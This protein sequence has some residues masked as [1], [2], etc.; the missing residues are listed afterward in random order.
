M[1]YYRRRQLSTKF[2]I[3]ITAAAI[4]LGLGAFY[5]LSDEQGARD[6]LTKAG[7]T[8]AQYK[9]HSVFGCGKGDLFK[10]SFSVKNPQGQRIDTVVCRGIFKGSTIRF[11]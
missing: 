6:T 7:Y 2:Q 4:P 1:S 3:A 11:D 9:G 10:D 8:D 5:G